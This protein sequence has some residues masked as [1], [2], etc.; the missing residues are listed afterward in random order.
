MTATSPLRRRARERLADFDRLLEA[1][2]KTPEASLG[3]HAD[4]L[5]EAVYVILSFQTD[6]AR[7]RTT[8]ARLKAALPSWEQLEEA[9]EFEVAQ[10][11][12]E[13]GL[14]RQKART[15]KQ[16]LIALRTLAGRLTLEDLRSI[17]TED[18]ERVLL[19][20]PGLSWKGARCVLLYSLGRDVL[21]IDSNT[22]RVLKR[23]GVLAPDAVY[24]RRPI[25][26]GIQ[27]LVP[28][29]RRRA[30]HINLVVHGQRT[31]LPVTP[32]CGECPARPVCAMCGVSLVVRREANR[33]AMPAAIAATECA[34]CA[35]C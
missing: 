30:L 33:R 18:A 24:R 7:L 15:I 10:V 12:R 16:L 5:D 28:A 27:S 9:S 20:L 32:K 1:A 35:D 29:G 17:G 14:H 25:H 19:R 8:W 26:D 22:F 34:R 11:L 13:G 21:P 3:N 23:A 4:P 2:Y 6:V 31:C